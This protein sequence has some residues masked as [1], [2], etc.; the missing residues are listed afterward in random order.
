MFL[1][2]TKNHEINDAAAP[3][4]EPQYEAQWQWCEGLSADIWGDCKAQ[5]LPYYTL[6]S[7][8]PEDYSTLKEKILST[9]TTIA[10]FQEWLY[11]LF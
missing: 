10:E 4:S 1:T 8:D 11:H 5:K 6:S 9:I 3:L 2:K 7:K